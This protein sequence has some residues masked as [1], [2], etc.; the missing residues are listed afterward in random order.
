MNKIEKSE[1]TYDV[2]TYKYKTSIEYGDFYISVGDLWKYSPQYINKDKIIQ[3]LSIRN[4]TYPFRTFHEIKFMY[5]EDGKESY[6]V[7]LRDFVLSCKQKV[8]A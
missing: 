2:P 4:T 1:P 3:I 7:R 5:L 8:Y 6:Y